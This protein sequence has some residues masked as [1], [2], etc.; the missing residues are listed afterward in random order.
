MIKTF[1]D[2]VEMSQSD[3]EEDEEEEEEEGEEEEELFSDEGEGSYDED[4]EEEN[5]HETFKQDTTKNSQLAVGFKDRSYVVRGDKIGVF[6]H[7]ER[8]GLDF[9]TTIK[10]L[11]NKAGRDVN[12]SR[13]S[14]SYLPMI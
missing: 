7:N 3:K 4:D 11:K 13:V 10:N 8:D 5:P 14:W 2:D 12:P 6:K 9:A 1:Q